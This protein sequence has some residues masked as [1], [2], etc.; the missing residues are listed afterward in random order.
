VFPVRYASDYINVTQKPR[1][2][3][4]R[5]DDPEGDKWFDNHSRV[6][7]TVGPK[8]EK[9]LVLNN[10]FMQEIPKTKGRLLHSFFDD[11]KQALIHAEPTPKMQ[12]KKEVT[13]L[14]RLWASV[15]GNKHGI[16]VFHHMIYA[17]YQGTT[18]KLFFSGNLWCWVK[19]TE[20]EYKASC[21][22]GG[23]ERAERA[24]KENRIIWIHPWKPKQE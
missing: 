12:I 2:L 6:R 19:E 18:M 5:P 7:T 8:H 4:V 3:V 13:I 9:E 15:N 24:L 16:D 21:F 20:T 17:K 1:H 14:E 22:Y 11:A 23:K 10:T